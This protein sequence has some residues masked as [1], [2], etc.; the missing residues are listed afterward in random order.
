MLKPCS[1]I[2][3]ATVAM[4][5]TVCSGFSQFLDAAELR[6]GLYNWP[7]F[8]FD[9]E[10]PYRGIDVDLA[11]E[12]SKRV[13]FDFTI[14]TCPFERCL[15]EMELGRLDLMSGIALTPKRAKYMDYAH[16]PYAEV[17]TAFFVRRGEEERLLRYEDLYNLQIGVVSEA[18]Y[19]D[20]F[21]ID[22][23]LNKT[24]FHSEKLMIKLLS[25]G[26]IDTFVSHQTTGAYEIMNQGF[27]GTLVQA[28]Y[29]P[30]SRI[31][32]YFAISQ[33]SPHRSLLPAINKAIKDIHADG[34]M[35]KILKKYR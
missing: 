6:M 17:S 16:F 8:S 3:Q 12:I 18:H 2:L 28:P 23:N 11:N 27:K 7:P 21:D 13:G 5:V 22:N 19:F 25:L 10:R 35:E 20:R 9:A 1:V 15:L 14:D 29:S 33:K 26:R 4:L 34:T 24:V 32:I 31:P 30:G